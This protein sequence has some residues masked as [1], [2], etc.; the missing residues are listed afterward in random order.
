MKNHSLFLCLEYI[1]SN[2]IEGLKLKRAYILHVA[3][4]ETLVSKILNL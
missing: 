4:S 1:I 2:V 3:V